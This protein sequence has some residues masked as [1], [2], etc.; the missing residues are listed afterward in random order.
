MAN[1]P[2]G[3]EHVMPYGIGIRL[4]RALVTQHWLQ[5]RLYAQQLEMVRKWQTELGVPYIKRI[6]TVNMLANTW[7]EWRSP[8]LIKHGVLDRWVTVSGEG[9]R[10]FEQPDLSC[11]MVIAVPHAVRIITLLQ[12]VVQLR[13]WETAK[14]VNDLMIKRTGDTATWSLQQTQSRTA[15]L[16]CAQQVLRRNGVVFI[17]ADGL[18]GKQSVD[19]SFWGRQRPFQIGAAELAVET[20]ALFIPAFVTINAIGR[21]QVE[22]TTPLTAQASSKEEKIIELTEK[23]GAL[24]AARWP[25][26]Y[27][28]MRWHHLAYNFNLPVV[29]L[30]AV[31]PAGRHPGDERIDNEF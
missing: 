10:L 23:H 2:V 14:V 8:A 12:H 11:G 31:D 20:C 1:G 22:I 30:P 3:G 13:G 19:V 21:V 27:A 6:L 5:Q 15:Q 29:R 25:Q 16:W 26:F 24:Y 18:Q 17:A 28:S 7:L 4:Q 9:W